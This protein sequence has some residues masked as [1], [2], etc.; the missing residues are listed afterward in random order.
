[1]P[2][3]SWPASTLRCADLLSRLPRELRDNIYADA[4]DAHGPVELSEDLLPHI[5][6]ILR[7]D[8]NLLPEALEVLAKMKTFTW[9][10]I[11]PHVSAIA[12]S[13][14]CVNLND[15]RH[16]E[17]T[18]SECAT[19]FKPSDFKSLDEHEKAYRRISSRIEWEK[20]LDLTHLQDLTIYIQKAQNSSLNTLDFS[21]ILYTLRAKQPNINITFFLSFDTIIQR[22]LDEWK[23]AMLE[24]DN[25]YLDLEESPYRPMGYVDMSD[26]ISPPTQEDRNYVQ[27]H[28][29]EYVNTAGGMPAHR[30]IGSGLLDETPA[31][32]RE[33]AKHYAVKEPALLRCLMRD[34]FDV[35]R[36]LQDGN[37]TEEST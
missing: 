2:E 26:L 12:S 35:Y 23:R 13:S 17:I 20:L 34:H 32:R 4:L 11:D 21:P 31:S 9:N 19:L 3:P 15:V 25:I 14:A 18:C 6:P 28:L 27:E 5:P 8:P 37:P 33:L 29:P 36:R 16:L 7:E 1:M 24:N 22:L 10:W 30:N